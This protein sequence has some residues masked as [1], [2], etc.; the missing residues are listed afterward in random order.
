MD[1]QQM[2]QMQPV[3]N[4]YM[5]Y[6]WRPQ[7][8]MPFQQPA[9]ITPPQQM[10]MNPTPP[11][12]VSMVQGDLEAS[13]FRVEPNQEVYL[14]DP[15]DIN[16]IILYTRRREAN[17]TLSPLQKFKMV[18]IEETPKQDPID[19]NQY[20]KTDDILDLINET[21]EKAVEKKLSEISFKPASEGGKSK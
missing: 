7:Q 1:M 11:K 5:Q 12:V 20:V 4:P 21:V 2:P 8:P 6:G 10:A 14:I 16:N 13:I 9:Y 15:N 3:N 19:M 17:G 18:T